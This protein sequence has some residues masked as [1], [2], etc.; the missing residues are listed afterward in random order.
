MAALVQ[1]LP[2][3]TGTITML[4]TRPSSS[5]ATYSAQQVQQQ[6]QMTRGNQ[7]SRNASNNNIMNGNYRGQGSPSTIAP[8]GFT[9][10]Q[11]PG[12][13]GNPSRQGVPSPHL[14][15]ENRTSSAPAVSLAHQLSDSESSNN[16]SRYASSNS[17]SISS[18]SAGSPSNAYNTSKDDSTISNSQRPRD[19]LVRPLSVSDL[20]IP[21]FHISDSPASKSSPDRYRR[22]HRRAETAAAA[23]MSQ[24]IQQAHSVQPSGSGMATVSHL[25]GNSGYGN[26][27]PTLNLPQSQ[28][29]NT[30]NYR[31]SPLSS[32]DD[33]PLY[34]HSSDQAVRYRRRSLGG[35]A[36]DA[37]VAPVNDFRQ[38]NSSNNKLQSKE[39]ESSNTAVVSRPVAQHGRDG[40]SESMS[41]ARS[42]SRPSSAKRDSSVPN[43]VLHPAGQSVPQ[44][45]PTSKQDPKSTSVSHGPPE[46]QKRVVNP[47]PL[48]HPVTASP[49]TP[50]AKTPQQVQSQNHPAPKV[51]SVS[52]AVQQL[53][54]VSKKDEKKKSRLRRAFSFGSAS[55]LRRA[56]AQN[57]HEHHIA[58]R[59]KLRKNQ[60]PEMDEEDAEQ[61]AIARKQEAAGL[62]ESI[63]SGQGHFF[64]GSTDNLSISSTASSASVMLRKM[65]KGMKKGTRS[66]V[67]LFR[68][69]SIVGVPAADKAVPQPSLAQV[70]IVNVE[71]EREKVNVND[72]PHSQI[73]G[74]TGFPK[75]ER[76][77]LDAAGSANIDT[78]SM[79]S[80]VSAS[81]STRRSIVGGE[82]ERAEVLAAVRKGIL[83]RMPVHPI[84]IIDREAN[85][86]QGTGTGNGTDSGNSSPVS[87]PLE[88]KTLDLNLPNIP[89]VNDTPNSSAP[90]TPS[91]DRPPRSGHR[92][93]DSVAIEGDD[94]FLSVARLGND[95]RRSSTPGTPHSGMAKNISF[96]PRIQ[97][98]DTWPSGEYDRRGDIAACNRLTP[99]LAQQIRE[100][101]NAL[102]MEMEVHEQSKIYTH[103]F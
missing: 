21:S 43:V 28:N 7:T 62:G 42:G 33:M 98:H 55:E 81:D 14:R 79:T 87:R 74:G 22:A 46:P 97:F 19:R 100:E 92:R 11:N 52:P 6:Q 44:P 26:S 84:C 23:P 66:I 34:R 32:T 29:M 82:R 16:R 76:N 69:K 41:S 77:S 64:S 91:D 93:T 38:P 72:D 78:P 47:S 17:S 1:T 35:F 48:S 30:G 101:I 65:G 58:E 50:K 75:L 89:H 39:N 51:A 4:Q 70:S 18:L 24:S 53:A 102:K 2:S 25:M 5:S 95:E 63:Y 56:S 61:A 20:V 15:I 59:T 49:P 3:Q 40:S 9:N 99:L 85:H 37:F 54:A 8:Y 45:M 96:S 73:G 86:G 10:T 13:G 12:Q 94:Y 90:S 88:L 27:S 83:K 68:P 57:S 31:R 67:G 36:T 103:F 60:E 80:S 71:A